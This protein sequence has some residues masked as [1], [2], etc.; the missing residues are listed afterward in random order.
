M[1]RPPTMAAPKNFA[2]GFNHNVQHRGRV[3]HVQTEDSGAEIAA[4]AT[5]LFAGA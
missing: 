4:I 2:T 5:H 3:Y 1:T